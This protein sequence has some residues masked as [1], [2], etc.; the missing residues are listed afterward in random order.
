M[1]SNLGFIFNDSIIDSLVDDRNSLLAF[2]HAQRTGGSNFKSMLRSAYGDASVYSQQTVAEY[3]HWKLLSE[4]DLA[5]YKVFAGH[6]DYVKKTE[7]SRR[8]GLFSIL[9]DPL[10]RAASLHAYCR[11]KEGHALQSLALSN[12]M[13]SF[14]REGVKLKPSYFSNV[15]CKRICGVADADL[16]IAHIDSYYAAVGFTERLQ[17][18]TRFLIERFG[19]G[20]EAL[21]ESTP[22]ALRYRGMICDDFKEIVYLSNVEDVKLFDLVSRRISN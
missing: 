7:F 15:Q 4:A 13:L 2:F 14:Y 5:G 21:S 17:E 19:W 1:N 11:S 6:S 9:R 10:Y 16:A 20:C 12:N 18:F 8:I 3:A 22:D